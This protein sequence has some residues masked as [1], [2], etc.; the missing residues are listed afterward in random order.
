MPPLTPIDS[1]RE[2]KLELLRQV[3]S[4]RD[5]PF[6]SSIPP[7]VDPDT[8]PP[9]DATLANALHHAF[10]RTPAGRIEALRMEIDLLR[11]L[12]HAR[13]TERV[14]RPFGVITL[15][16]PIRRDGIT[17]FGLN[18]GPLK[19]G[20]WNPRELETLAKLCNCLVPQLPQ[21]L[22]EATFYSS[23]QIEHLARLQLGQA[24]LLEAALSLHSPAPT[25]PPPPEYS[26]ALD[27]LQPGFAD[28]IDLLFS[29]IESLVR[30]GQEVDLPARRRITMASQ[31]GRHLLDQLRL[32]NREALAVTEDVAIH[33]LL[34][35]WTEELSSLVDGLRFGLKLQ[36]T[37][38][39]IHTHPGALRHL[40]R[41][42][43]HAVADGLPEGA[44][45]GVETRDTQFEGRPAL[46]LNIRDSGGSATF[47]GIGTPLDL[48]MLAEQNND[49]DSAEWVLLAERIDVHLRILRDDGIITRVEAFLPYETGALGAES[50]GPLPTVWVVED[51]DRDYELLLHLL[52]DAGV[53]AVRLRTGADLQQEYALSPAIP[54]LVLLKYNLPDARGNEL[55]LWLYGQDPDLPVILTSGLAATHPGI[56][57]AAGLPSTLFL[58]KPFDAQSLRDMLRMT[59]CDTLPN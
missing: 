11:R 21:A 23:T 3:F 20:P 33:P 42:L 5:T 43:L 45:I 8:A 29:T 59:L 4:L 10:Q 27:I 36:A 12:Q 51:D 49:A 14:F 16:T 54:D 25:S 41:T 2:Q 19:L 6:S 26:P 13:D 34:A 40:L 18:S 9:L 47:A 1:L 48:E 30:P 50:G 28:H 53:R 52:H 44:F 57:T 35:Q 58:Q 39:R 31:R 38:D 15:V 32:L 56:A 37:R 17:V 46:H 22:G 7:E 24:R 55:R